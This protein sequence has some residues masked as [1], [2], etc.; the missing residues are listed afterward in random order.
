MG[1]VMIVKN[2]EQG[3]TMIQTIL[4]FCILIALSVS[5]A[6]NISGIFGRYKTG[7]ISQQVV[8]LKKAIIQYSAVDEDYTNVTEEALENSNSIPLDMRALRHALGGKIEFGPTTEIT[9][10]NPVLATDRYMYYITFWSVNKNACV[11]VLSKGQ[12]FTDGSELD[13][14][15]INDNIA[16]NY[17]FSQF[18]TNHIASVN[19]LQRQYLS[20]SEAI[21]SCTRKI[22]NKITWIFT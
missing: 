21:S 22:D 5:I 13:A 18:E 8:E 19:K 6:K 2:N 1:D 14:I 15:I 3:N 7:R 11:E 12:F 17:T 9:S 10:S 4:Y 16:W 20:L